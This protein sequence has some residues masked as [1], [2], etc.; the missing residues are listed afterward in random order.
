MATTAGSL[1]DAERARRAARILDAAGA[2][3][4]ELGYGKVT[5]EDVARRAGIGK[6]TVYLHFPTKEVLFGMVVVRAQVQVGTGLIEGMRADPAMIMPAAVARSLY[7]VQEDTPLVNAIFTR[8]GSALGS[9][10]ETLGRTQGDLIG[11]RARVMQDFFAALRSHGLLRTDRTVEEQNYMFVSAVMGALTSPPLLARQS[12]P[13]PDAR[14][15]ADILAETVHRSLERTA[16]PSVLRAARADVV[17]LFENLMGR[18][19]S[20]LEEYLP[21]V[22]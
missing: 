4:T 10:V 16:G 22:E 14:T 9:V 11:L 12:Y 19:R 2:L 5:V 13:V 18:A 8:D 17:P 1:R 7:L 15:R 21:P 6:G 20:V 3:L